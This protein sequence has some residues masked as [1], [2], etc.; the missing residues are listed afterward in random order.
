MLTKKILRELYYQLLR[1]RIVEETI[2]S[3]YAKQEMRCP[4]HLCIGHEAIPVG[5]CAH[6]KKTDFVLSNHRSHGHYL[7]KGGDLK[8]LI[9]ELYGK[10][11]GVSRG[12]GGSQ[13]LIDLSAGFLASTP[14]VGGTIP[15][16]VGSAFVSKMKKEKSIAVIFFG[17]AA[18][19]EGV[20]YESLNFALLKKLSVLFVCENNLYSIFTHISERQPDRPIYK[21]VAGSGVYVNQANGNELID[22]YQNASKAIKHIRSG[23]GPAFLECMTYR[24][25][26]HCGP[27]F[28]EEGQRD[29]LIYKKWMKKDPVILFELYLKKRNVLSNMEKIKIENKIQKEVD[30]AFEFAKKSPF[31][32]SGLSIHDVYA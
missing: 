22:V 15:V 2:A 16:G 18:I 11:T 28:E 20:F 10:E 19:E 30:E 12:R 6:L 17:D 7:A 25:R 3:E 23:K 27:L 5:V 21:M 29:V 31:P 9:A 26:E 1:I 13:H 4:T 24:Y 8:G 32:K 14:I